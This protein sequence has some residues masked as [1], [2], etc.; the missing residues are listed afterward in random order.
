M[1]RERER[2]RER[3]KKLPESENR[4]ELA[5]DGVGE[6]ASKE[7]SEVSAKNERVYDHCGVILREMQTIHKIRGQD[8]FE[9]LYI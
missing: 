1:F 7:W 6:P 5:Q 2:E 9:T 4:P 8:R 3:T